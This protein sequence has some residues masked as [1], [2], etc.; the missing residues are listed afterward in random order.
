MNNYGSTSKLLPQ[1][2]R[3]IEEIDAAIYGLGKYHD[4][5]DERIESLYNNSF[6]YTLELDGIE[7]YERRYNLKPLG[8]LQDRRSAIMAYRK[9]RKAK[10]SASRVKEIA[11]SYT[12]GETNVYFDQGRNS[13]VVQFISLYG[14]PTGLEKLKEILEEFKPARLFIEYSL[15]Y[16]L[17]R[18]IQQMTLIELQA[19]PISKFSF[20]REIIR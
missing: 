15:R 4:K 19:T 8:S 13:L 20:G 14:I 7:E 3:E 5:V 9:A 17:V 10:L 2:I 16:L 1:N 12:N 18:D 11:L 6:F